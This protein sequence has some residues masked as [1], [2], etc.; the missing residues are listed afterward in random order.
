MELNDILDNLT[1]TKESR[2]DAKNWFA[3][4]FPFVQAA[5]ALKDRMFSLD[6]PEKQ[7]NIIELATDLLFDR[8][9]SLLVLPYSADEYG[10]D[11]EIC[12]PD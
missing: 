6:D 11:C 9:Y 1:G 4:S 8:Y 12:A 10:L 3:Q 7:L 5:Q 2:T